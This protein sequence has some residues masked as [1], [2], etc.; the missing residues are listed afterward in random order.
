MTTVG[1]VV[2]GLLDRAH[3]DAERRKR[4]KSY[5]TWLNET[6]EDDRDYVCSAGQ[7][8]LPSGAALGLASAWILKN[9]GR[10]R[11]VVIR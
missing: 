10:G 2:G 3:Q 7:S 8:G 9:S 11:V 6:D 4:A 1:H 5:W